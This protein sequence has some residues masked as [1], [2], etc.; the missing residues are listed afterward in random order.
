ML[1]LNLKLLHTEVNFVM[2]LSSS[3]WTL[4]MTGGSDFMRN[5][6]KGKRYFG[7]AET[8]LWWLELFFLYQPNAFPTDFGRWRPTDDLNLITAVTQV[9]VET[10]FC[11]PSFF[12]SSCN[13]WSYPKICKKVVPLVKL[14]PSDG[15]IA[16]I[17]F[18][19]DLL[20]DGI[21]AS[22]IR[23]QNFY[24]TDTFIWCR[25]SCW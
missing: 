22:D 4:E 14:M 10:I 3:K 6:F 8:F 15:R 13:F 7:E 25:S 5:I 24:V 11:F 2:W 16:L 20:Y 21:L 19:V 23:L 9:Y 18:L 12:R 17:Q 1:Y